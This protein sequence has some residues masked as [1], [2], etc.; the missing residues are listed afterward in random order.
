MPLAVDP[1]STSIA[2][3]ALVVLALSAGFQIYA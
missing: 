2:G 3:V 1:V